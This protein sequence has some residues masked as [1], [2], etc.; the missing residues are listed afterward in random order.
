MKNLIK[1]LFNK[2]LK[3]LKNQQGL[4][5]IELLVVIVILGIIAAIAI[6][7]VVNNKNEAAENAAKQ[8]NAIVKDAVARYEAVE[9]ETPENIDQLITKY[10]KEKPKCPDDDYKEVENDLQNYCQKKTE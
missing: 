3:L 5:L 9:G 1:K 8:T 2:K 6:P 4:T 10:L 7:M